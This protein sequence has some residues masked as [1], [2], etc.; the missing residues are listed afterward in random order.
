MYFYLL[1]TYV[2]PGDSED[3]TDYILIEIPTFLYMGL[4]LLLP[5]SLFPPSLSSS[6]V[7]PTG[8]FI[9]IVLSFLFVYLR[10]Y[11]D[12]M[13]SDRVFWGC[14]LASQIFIWLSFIAVVVALATLD[15]GG[16]EIRSCS[17]R[18]TDE[19]VSEKDDAR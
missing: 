17:G 3:V 18:L 5:S 11:R 10:G 14:F 9:L 7:L 15:E 2:V 12:I 13:L 4:S 1:G 19:T 8:M 6:L 16:E